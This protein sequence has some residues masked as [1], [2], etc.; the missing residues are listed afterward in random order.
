MRLSGSLRFL[1]SL[2]AVL[3][4]FTG[5]AEAAAGRDYG[6]AIRALMDEKYERAEEK[7]R[8]ALED[9][10][11]AKESILISGAT[12]YRYLPYYVLGAALR[13][14]GRCPEALEAW[15]ESIRQ[16]QVQQANEFAELEAGAV[17]CG[18]TVAALSGAEAAPAPTAEPPAP[19]ADPALAQQIAQLNDSIEASLTQLRQR[20]ARFAGLRSDTDLAPEWF[21]NWQPRLAASEAEYKRLEAAFQQARQASDVTML[22]PLASE[23][24]E[25]LNDI[26]AQ[27]LAAQ[28]RID[29]LSQERLAQA[30]LLEEERNRQEAL[31]QQRLAAERREREEA[32]QRRRERDAREAL[33]VA[34]RNLRQEL[35]SLAPVVR[36][37]GGDEGVTAA[38]NQ[39]AQLI[40]DGRA[41]QTNSSIDRL[42]QQIQALR[43]GQRRYNQ[44]FQ[45]W[46]AQQREIEYRTPPDELRRI[47]DAYFSGDYE[48]ALRLADPG[49]FEDSRQV[50]QAY[51][52]RSAARYN[53]Y[54]LNGSSD[55]MLRERAREDIQEIK[56]LD[57]GFEPYVA[58]FSPKFVDFFRES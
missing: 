15:R 49:A 50:I 48:T 39:L 14:Q 1:L 5:Q 22:E 16:G 23:L 44:V 45:E 47:A 27:Q 57:S 6:L 13:G 8:E 28:S 19:A 58:A 29:S 24:N 2:T 56:K 53:L 7:I 9:E 31:T 12:R 54:W 52:F 42:D 26:E 4:L 55:E 17:A 32:D 35:D 10:S 40:R 3:V 20:N 36:E 25:A 37:T 38:R 18:T 33:A 21:S 34:Q 30:A 41:L 46:E 51:L 11:Q 43:D